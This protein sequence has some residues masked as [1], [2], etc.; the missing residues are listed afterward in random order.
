MGPALPPLSMAGAVAL[1]GGVGGGGC[2]GVMGTDGGGGP[3]GVLV[4]LPRRAAWGAGAWADVDEWIRA[5]GL[6]FGFGFGSAVAAVAGHLLDV[7]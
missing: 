4:V 1:C 7:G 6:R 2:G 3:G 5:Q